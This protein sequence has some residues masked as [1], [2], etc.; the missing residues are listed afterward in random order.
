MRSFLADQD[1][2]MRAVT[3]AQIALLWKEYIL[4]VLKGRQLCL[5]LCRFINI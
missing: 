4:K 3:E 2:D 5:W 1:M